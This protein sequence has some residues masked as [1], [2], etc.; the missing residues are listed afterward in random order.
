[1]KQEVAQD[2]FSMNK[3]STKWFLETETMF[4]TNPY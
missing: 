4:A 2:S 1:M 3:V